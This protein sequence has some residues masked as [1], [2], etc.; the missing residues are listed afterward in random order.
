MGL[1][2]LGSIHP[3]AGGSEA[4]PTPPYTIRNLPHS[5]PIDSQIAVA[6]K[7]RNQKQVTSRYQ[8]FQTAVLHKCGEHLKTA[9]RVPPAEEER[10]TYIYLF[11]LGRG[12]AGHET[13]FP[14]LAI[15][16]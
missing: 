3:L 7:A 5:Y 6:K 15:P 1:G 16:T 2:K 11:S 14:D 10:P 13:F 12:D 4:I 8:R 9:N